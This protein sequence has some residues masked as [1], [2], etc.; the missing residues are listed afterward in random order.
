[1]VTVMLAKA[2]FVIIGSPPRLPLRSNSSERRD[3]DGTAQRRNRYRSL[4]ALLVGLL[5]IA[6]VQAFAQDAAKEVKP[7]IHSELQAHTGHFDKKVYKVADNV[8]SVVGYDLANTI[9][10]EGTDGVIIVDTGG[11]IESARTVAAELKKITSKPVVAGIYTHFHPD[12]INGVKAYTT[13]DEVK[14]GGVAIYAQEMLLSFNV[15]LNQTA[16]D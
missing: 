3:Q 15:G 13:E 4:P 6:S 8:Y 5:L 12:H 16:T 10:V 2:R 11:R 14:A 9:M 1:V 7:G